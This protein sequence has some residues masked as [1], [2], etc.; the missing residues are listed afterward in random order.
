MARVHIAPSCRLACVAHAQ[1][2]ADARG[3]GARGSSIHKSVKASKPL[4]R[5]VS[6][7]ERVYG[8]RV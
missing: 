7:F 8:L 4:E 6:R 2:S 5:P 1:G 3:M